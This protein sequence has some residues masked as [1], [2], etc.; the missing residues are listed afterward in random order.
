M[1]LSEQRLQRNDPGNA[2]YYLEH[3]SLR[4]DVPNF[5]VSG[6][7]LEKPSDAF[8]FDET[9]GASCPCYFSVTREEQK[10]KNQKQ[11]AGRIHI[12]RVNYLHSDCGDLGRNVLFYFYL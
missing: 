7:Q 3:C 5:T 6:I 4:A 12:S 8:H 2:Q 10:W 1:I 11:T 9:F